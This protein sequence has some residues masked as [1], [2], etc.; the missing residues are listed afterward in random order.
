M[1][2]HYKLAKKFFETSS[3]DSLLSSIKPDKEERKL[4]DPRNK[5]KS[6]C[7]E[8]WNRSFRAISSRFR[9]EQLVQRWGA[10]FIQPFR[11]RVFIVAREAA[12]SADRP[13]YRRFRHVESRP[14][15]SRDS[16]GDNRPCRYTII[17]TILSRF[18]PSP[19]GWR[20]VALRIIALI[21]VA[22]PNSLGT[23]VNSG[24]KRVGR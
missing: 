16:I 12:L 14:T 17:A 3:Y 1:R 10:P 5:N 4:F 13:S 18:T 7:S 21:R 19:N 20:G 22:I 8:A 23:A 9:R 24:M 2:N 15:E 6:I 11:N